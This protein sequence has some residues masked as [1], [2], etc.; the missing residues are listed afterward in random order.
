MLILI[1]WQSFVAIGQGS[2]EILWR[3]KK[4]TTKT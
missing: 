3:I 2:S 1:T 4:T